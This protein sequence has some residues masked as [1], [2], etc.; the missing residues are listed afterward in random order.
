M[1]EPA[2]QAKIRVVLCA[3]DEN[4]I[5]IFDQRHSQALDSNELIK[6]LF[7]IVGKTAIA[8]FKL[9]LVPDAARTKEEKA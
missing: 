1:I 5:Q 8:S 6:T 2:I 9:H 3:I 7:R 4:P